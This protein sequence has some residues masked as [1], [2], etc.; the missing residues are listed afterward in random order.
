MKIRDYLRMDAEK[1]AKL[2][3]VASFVSRKS[4]GRTRPKKQFSPF[5]GA[6]IAAILPGTRGVSKG[7]LPPP[8]ASWASISDTCNHNCSGC[9]FGKQ[10]GRED[11]FMNPRNFSRLLENL[12]HLKVKSLHLSGGG[13]PALHPEFDEFLQMCMQERLD[14]S[15]LTNAASLKPDTI[16][17]LVEG[18]SF[19]RVN[20]DASSGQVYSRIHHPV[21][22]GEF[23]RV[24]AN[25]EGII[26]ERERRRSGLILGAEVRLCQTNM[27]FMEETVCLVR[28]LGL[29]YLQFRINRNASN[30]LLPDQED[31]V[32][33]LIE[34]L[35]ESLAPFP[36]Y[37]EARA[38]SFDHGCRISPV[39]LVM[40]SSGDVYPC[41]HFARHREDTSFGT[42]FSQSAE[43]L[44]QGEL[45]RRIVKRLSE[46]VCDI[47]GCRW[48][49]CGA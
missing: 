29:D 30:P 11:P 4:V 45:H 49:R 38:K 22:S 36:V 12:R 48:R 2:R 3:A 44:W 17:L 47:P 8:V 14:L 32:N 26:A 43:E 15:L 16:K 5:E 34:E 9:L 7:S 27:N 37:G 18:L 31:R 39:I 42:I 21:R 24:L 40:N 46:K 20:L 25:L 33:N 6:V 23:D 28:D 1:E 19:L 41:F 13:D 35:K 10:S